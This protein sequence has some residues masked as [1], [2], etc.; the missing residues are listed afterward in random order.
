MHLEFRPHNFQSLNLLRH[1][2]HVTGRILFALFLLT[3]S[4]GGPQA[5]GQE[6]NPKESDSA[7]VSFGRFFRE[8]ISA[9]GSDTLRL[10]H[11]FVQPG[12]ISVAIDPVSELAQ[13]T[14][15]SLD[16]RA[17]EIILLPAGRA[18]LDSARV[19]IL[20]ISYT[21]LPYRFQRGYRLR[22]LLLRRDTSR[23]DTIRFAPVS[24]TLTI[25]NVFGAG[26]QKSGYI[27]RGFTIGSSRDLTLNSGFRLQLSGKLSDDIDIVA[28]LTDENTP[29]Q[30]EGN[31][32]T[33]QELDKVF[34]RLSSPHLAATLG[35]FTLSLS[36]TEFGS[37]NRK[38]AGALAEA[39]SDIGTASVSW[40]SMKGTYR[41]M[42]F[43]GIDGMQGPYRLTGKNGEPRIVVLAG[44]ER[45]YVDGVEM[46]RGENNDYVI[47]YAGGEITFKPR[48]LIT[49]FSRIT[50]DFE[51]ADRLYSRALF[52]ADATGKAFG[53][54]LRV[55]ARYLQEGDDPD[56]PIEFELS[57]ADRAVLAAAGD[58]PRKASAPGAAYVGIDSARGIGA[59]AYIRADTLIDGALT[60]Y[61]RYEPGADSA[62]YSVTFSFVGA[63]MGEYAR[64]SIGY[65][66]FVGPGRGD[67]SPLRLLPVPE[68]RRLADLKAAAEPLRGLKLSAEAAL[69]EADGNRFS[70]LDSE[71]NA[72]AAANISGELSLKAGPLGA[73]DIG[74]RYRHSSAAFNPIDRI[75][76]IEF[77]RRWNTG[78]AA[79]ADESIREASVTW[80][81]SEILKA[82]IGGGSYNRGALSS[83]RAEGTF[84]IAP[85]SGDSALPAVSYGI[86][87]IRSDDG[88]VRGNWL[89]Q[90]AAASY[91]LSFVEPTFRFESER[92]I[93][94]GG[95]ADTLA[96]N[97]MAFLDLRPGFRTAEFW[98][99]TL[100]AEFGFRDEDAYLDGALRDQ[101]EDLIQQYSWTLRAWHD[102]AAS[103]AVTIRD[104]RWSED[105]RRTGNKDLQTILTSSQIQYSAW[106]RALSAN[107]L[108][109]VSTEKTSKLER[110]FLKVPFGQGNYIYAGDRNGNGIAEEYEYEPTR[111]DGEYVALTLPTDEL[112]PVIDLRAG[113]R[114]NVRPSLALSSS[115]NFLRSLLRAVSSETYVR[116]E[117]KSSDERTSNIYML[118]TSAFLNEE[119]TIRGSQLM[120]QDIFLFERNADLSLRFRYEQNRGFSQYALAD[121][122]SFRAERSVRLRSQPVREIGLQADLAF[123][124]D[125]A[126]SA[127]AG[128]RTRA[129]NATAFNG[130]FSYRPYRSVEVGFVLG[131]TDATDTYPG[132][133]TEADINSLTLRAVMSFEGPGRLRVELERSDVVLSSAVSRYPFELTDGK[134]EGKSWVLRVNFDYRITSFLQAGAGYL[135]RSEGGSAF[136]HTARAEVRAFF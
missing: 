123:R 6:R 2:L 90:R 58:D 75:D 32:R 68:L 133:E 118:R 4:W 89:R 31:T 91:R 100:G 80:R 65:Y 21:A 5:E 77:S 94:T 38:L 85:R 44:T 104:R 73:V 92:R 26:L 11:G 33:L 70:T 120:R 122:R 106:R 25:E 53:E 96:Q 98:N 74:A 132:Q 108:Y 81:P 43:N 45:V 48:R 114:L 71:D 47:E 66:R 86:E 112:F 111:F 20:A 22:E 56:A 135:G 124:R 59:G 76:E 35:D 51:Y 119:T 61:Y 24:S 27:G 42:Q 63:G 9:A 72:G 130:D 79:R 29:I 82:G 88:A 95:A 3:T 97:S 37:Y 1:D 134:A 17:G 113:A 109:E 60:V 131:L 99:M 116:I 12:A 49:S 69:S 16:A 117:E 23:G 103:A 129:I 10:Q 55:T 102:L 136:I 127:Q 62:T 52:T 93:N 28:A 41:S 15:F 126:T 7:A 101:S 50:V 40:A 39:G 105:F 14:E 84:A 83:R 87:W 128:S 125:G 67:Y 46:T 54:R 110:V 36:G 19:K 8:L 115:D 107:L 13:G 18:R 78:A 30:P 34:I 57:D 64:Q 121:E